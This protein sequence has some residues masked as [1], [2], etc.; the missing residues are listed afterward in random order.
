MRP[1]RIALHISALFLL[2]WLCAP[3]GSARYAGTDVLEG[4]CCLCI[5]VEANLRLGERIIAES[6]IEHRGT[7]FSDSGCVTG[8]PE[9]T[10]KRVCPGWRPSYRNSIFLRN[11]PV[12]CTGAHSTRRSRFLLGI[13]YLCVISRVGDK[14]VM[15]EQLFPGEK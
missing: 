13:V 11:P 9:V 5:G 12:T 1:R 3:S 4:S 6:L 2:R 7:R 14:A 15:L 10:P 8:H